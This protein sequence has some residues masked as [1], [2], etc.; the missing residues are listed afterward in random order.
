MLATSMNSDPSLKSII[1]EAIYLD[2]LVPDEVKAEARA[3]A[4]AET[5]MSDKSIY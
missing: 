4:K 2:S 5:S 3:L 1:Q